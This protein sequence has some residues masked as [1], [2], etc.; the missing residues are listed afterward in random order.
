MQIAVTRVLHRN[1]KLCHLYLHSDVS[2]LCL[3]I[4]YVAIHQYVCIYTYMYVYRY[5]CVHA[6]IYEYMH[7]GI[8]V[9]R[10]T[11][12]HIC[13][14][15]STY[16]CARSTPISLY[17][18]LISLNKYGCHIAN[19]THNYYAKW[20]YRPNILHLF[21]KIQPTSIYTSH[22]IAMYGLA[23]NIPHIQTISSARLNYV[24]I[25]TS[26]HSLKSTV[27]LG[28]SIPI[29]TFQIICICL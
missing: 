15:V 24:A 14:H 21:A 18:Y 26:Y 29:H 11:W 6:C 28:R 16:V 20:A 12:L 1:V 3:H 8:S 9:T 19:M 23:T 17:M 2:M 27:W 13:M 22:N 25:N 7:F 4:I 10:H 5:V